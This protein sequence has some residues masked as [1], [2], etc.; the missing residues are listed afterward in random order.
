[1]KTFPGTFPWLVPENEV[2]STARKGP[3]G[4]LFLEML[5]FRDLT[6]V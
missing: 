2:D 5:K 3:V 4:Y 6:E 1:M